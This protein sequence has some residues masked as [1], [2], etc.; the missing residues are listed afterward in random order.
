MNR[1]PKIG[2]IGASLIIGIAA[3]SGCTE[4]ADAAEERQVN[5]QQ[6]LYG[7]TQPI[8]RYDWSLA[9]HLW[10]QFYDSQ[11]TAVA[12]FSYIRPN[13]GG[14]PSFECASMGYALPRDTQLSNPLQRGH[15]GSVIEQ[16]E[17]NGLFTSK[18][19]AQTVIFCLNN[20]GTVAPVNTE[21]F[22]TAFPFP[23]KWEGPSQDYPDG[24]WI[25]DG[26]SNV[27]LDPNREES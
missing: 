23:V 3:L 25:R 6:E 18:N 4:G 11:N 13:M 26:D 2:A 5:E 8:P 17:P 27:S 22:V 16:A 9:R 24:R 20:D 15:N 7:D 1:I 12:T 21:E 14:A 10:V 19:T